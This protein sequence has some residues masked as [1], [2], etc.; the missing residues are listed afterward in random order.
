MEARARERELEMEAT[1]REREARMEERMFSM[2]GAVV[3]I[4]SRGG[5]SRPF[6]QAHSGY[7]P[8]MD[9]SPT[10]SS[11]SQDSPPPPLNYH[12]SLNYESIKRYFVGGKR[13]II[14]IIIS[15]Y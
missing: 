6:Y 2:F 9:Y 14:T 5:S 7:S 8:P 10:S 11:F 1:F 4:A 13:I 3:Q 12:N 15:I